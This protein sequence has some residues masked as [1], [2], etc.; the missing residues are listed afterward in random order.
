M[1][2]YISKGDID[3][4]KEKKIIR[5]MEL[6]NLQ[7]DSINDNLIEATF[8]GTSYTDVKTARI[9]II[10]WLPD[11]GNIETEVVMPNAKVIKGLAEPS[12][13]NEKIENTVQLM[14]FGFG[15][16]DNFDNKLLRIYFSHS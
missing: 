8:K 6:F 7:V 1:R 14:R 9:P 16:I 11:K 15:R 13:K 5:L 10:H 12:L 3:L 2:L 4:L